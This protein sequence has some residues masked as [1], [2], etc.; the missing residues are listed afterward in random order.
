MNHK[1]TLRLP[2]SFNYE[3]QTLII[4]LFVLNSG[5]SAGAAWRESELC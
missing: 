3:S 4:G 1:L 2:V 5:Q